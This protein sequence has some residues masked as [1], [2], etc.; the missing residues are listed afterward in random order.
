MLYTL[1]N[2]NKQIL[3]FEYNIEYNA[4]LGVKKVIDLNYAPY[5]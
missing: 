3:V 5:Y 4:Y 1:M 2:K